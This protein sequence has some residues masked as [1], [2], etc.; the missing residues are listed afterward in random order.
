MIEIDL[1]K[2]TVEQV[3]DD[4][5]FE[6]L[7]LEDR[8]NRQWISYPPQPMWR[9]A[10]DEFKQALRERNQLIK[11]EAKDAAAKQA[12][13]LSKER[14]KQANKDAARERMRRILRAPHESMLACLHELTHPERVEHLGTSVGFGI[15][16]NSR[17]LNS[18]W[19]PTRSAR[20]CTTAQGCVGVQRPSVYWQ[21]RIYRQFVQD[22]PPGSYISQVDAAALRAPRSAWT[23]YLANCSMRNTSPRWKPVP[24]ATKEVVSA[25]YFTDEENALIP[26]L[27]EPFDDLFAS[28]GGSWRHLPNQGGPASIHARA[29]PSRQFGA[30]TRHPAGASDA[31][32]GAST[33]RITPRPRNAN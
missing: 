3:L 12:L 20:P 7:V 10:Y 27:Y 33:E 21:A 29:S 22:A 15:A 32:S 11:A 18:S 1:S 9:I 26:S 28:V 5:E 23:R 2:V 31:G 6:R 25:W 19:I 13:A 16:S 17:C 4:V 24:P 30:G 8:G 14:A